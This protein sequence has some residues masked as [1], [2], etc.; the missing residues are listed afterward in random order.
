MERGRGLKRPEQIA[1]NVI[2]LC[3]PDGWQVF[4]DSAPKHGAR[5]SVARHCGA[6]ER[7]GQNSAWNGYAW[8][9]APQLLLEGSIGSEIQLDWQA[10]AGESQSHAGRIPIAS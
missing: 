7:V 9:Q 3:A 6:S 2:H 5:N 8:A 4:H 10:A 1:P